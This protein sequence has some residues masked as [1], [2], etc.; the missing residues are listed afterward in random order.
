MWLEFVYSENGQQDITK[1][2][3]IALYFL[4]EEDEI[5]NKVLLGGGREE[6]RHGAATSTM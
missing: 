1:W 4:C 2:G 5:V 3:S 6:G